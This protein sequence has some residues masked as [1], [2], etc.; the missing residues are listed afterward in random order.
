[1]NQILP[2]NYMYLFMWWAICISFSI[3][4]ITL[5]A[6]YV[7]ASNKAKRND[8]ALATNRVAMILRKFVFVWAL[9][10]LLVFYL[11]SVLIVSIVLFAIGNI[12]VEAL[13]L[14]YLLKNRSKESE[15]ES[16]Q[17]KVEVNQINS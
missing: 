1:M 3:L 5:I 10:G 14:I 2:E 11:V 7:Y 13:L 12:I 15:I 6:V 4:F 16:T 17:E 8:E 9:I